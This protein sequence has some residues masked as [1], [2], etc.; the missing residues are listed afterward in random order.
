MGA[1]VVPNSSFTSRIKRLISLLTFLSSHRLVEQQDRLGGQHSSS[2]HFSIPFGRRATGVAGLPQFQK[3]DNFSPPLR[4]SRLPSRSAA[5]PDH[6]ARI[7]VFA[8]RQRP[9]ITLSRTLMPLKQ[10][11]VL[12]CPRNPLLRR[13]KGFI[14]GRRSPLSPDLA[15]LRRSRIA[16]ASGYCTVRPDDRADLALREYQRNILDCTRPTS[17]M[18]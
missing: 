1:I 17:N 4:G 7:P 15:I 3:I 6:L 8:S 11:D 2:T 16:L 5:P 13:F 14:A 18:G 10:S 9:V 12:E